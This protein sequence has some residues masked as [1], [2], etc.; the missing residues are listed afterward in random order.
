VT[1]LLPLWNVF[2]SIRDW[3]AAAVF[4]LV[5]ACLGLR[6]SARDNQV[7]LSDPRLP[8]SV[9]ELRIDNLRVGDASVDLLARRHGRDAGVNVLRREGGLRVNMLT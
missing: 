5:Q 1:A 2:G 3:P 9:K 8:A 6:V 7:V 4:L